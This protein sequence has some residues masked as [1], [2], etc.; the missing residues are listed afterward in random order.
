VTGAHSDLTVQRG[1]PGVDL[2]AAALA[3]IRRAG[4]D[5]DLWL[6]GADTFGDASQP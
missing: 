2:V 4:V 3:D 6:P 5:P 1:T